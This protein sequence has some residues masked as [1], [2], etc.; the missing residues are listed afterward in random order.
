MIGVVLEWILISLVS[1]FARRLKLAIVHLQSLPQ[2]M[3]LM[4]FHKGKN[5]KIDFEIS[6]PF[7]S[8]NNS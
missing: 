1:S 4:S 2:L 6:T 7:L 8:Y 3:I 5:Y